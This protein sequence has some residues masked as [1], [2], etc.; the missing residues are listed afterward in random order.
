[1]K[2]NKGL[3]I[4][5]ICIAV[6]IAGIVTAMIL[7]GVFSQKGKEEN[8]VSTT[9]KIEEI[10]AFSAVPNLMSKIIRK[11]GELVKENSIKNYSSPVQKAIISIDS[12]LTADLSLNHLS[13]IQNIS[14]AYLSN[15]FHKE[16]GDTL[17][18]FVNKKRISY[19]K[20]LLD[21][22]NMQIQAV[23]QRCGIVDI[24]Y[25][26]R[27]FKKQVGCTPKEYREKSIKN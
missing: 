6:A 22:T 11:Y 2:N 5:I 14:P 8:A 9:A 18:D 26:S 23:A 19:A 20:R 16:T 13:S 24:H 15:I 12:D 3:I 7:T 4:A 1:M 10:T 17:T 25:F 21:T 27:I